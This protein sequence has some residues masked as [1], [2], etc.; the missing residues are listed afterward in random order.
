LI[1][2]GRVTVNGAVVREMGTKVEP[3]KDDVRLDG[4]ALEAETPKVTV[5]L[6]KPD[7]VVT[8]LKDPE[9]RATVAGL[10]KAESYRL[11]PIGRLDFHVE[12]VLLLST[13]GDLVNGLLKREARVPKTYAVKVGGRPK[14]ADLDRLRAG[15]E[16][17]RKKTDRTMVE[18]LEQAERHAWLELIVTDTRRQPIP[19]MME[20]IGHRPLRIVRTGF[21]TV[22]LEDLRPGQYRYLTG[23]E[24]G[25]LY[26]LA[27][28]GR[29]PEMPEDLDLSVHGEAKRT[30]GELPSATRR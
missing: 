10:L 30:R 25:G 20:A 15:V 21:S 13:D 18:L 8:T 28:L 7:A 19:E 6:Y 12:G 17:D 2:A 27:G 9:G 1:R 5:V 22:D 14:P 11:V 3:G 16:I 4:Q 24:L 26:R 29:A 23:A